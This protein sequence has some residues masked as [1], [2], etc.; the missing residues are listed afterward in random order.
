VLA[1]GDRRDG[2]GAFGVGDGADLDACVEVSDGNFGSGDGKSGWVLDGALDCGAAAGLSVE[3][4]G[5]EG[6]K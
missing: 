1:D 2:I 5:D 6:Q 3:G 4:D